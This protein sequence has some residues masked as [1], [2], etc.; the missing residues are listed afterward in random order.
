[1]A[2]SSSI[3]KLQVSDEGL[4]QEGGSYE[5]LAGKLAANTAPT[6][7]ESSGLASAAAITAALGDVAA[8]NIRCTSRVQATAGKLSAAAIGYTEGEDSSLAQ[9]RALMTPAVR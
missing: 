1:M 9:L 4:R 3:Q 6:G 5:P 8:A 2:S 7:T